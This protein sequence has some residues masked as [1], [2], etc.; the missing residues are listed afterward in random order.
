[1]DA[2]QHGASAPQG[3]VEL[4]VHRHVSDANNHP[5]Q[6][7]GYAPSLTSLSGNK[8]SRQSKGEQTD[9]MSKLLNVEHGGYRC[10]ALATA[11]MC[12]TDRVCCRRDRGEGTCGRRGVEESLLG[13]FGS[14]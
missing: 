1:M 6:Q 12:S 5:G 4:L 3:E 7:Q 13:P 11:E 2:L 10:N 14:S 8:R 9:E